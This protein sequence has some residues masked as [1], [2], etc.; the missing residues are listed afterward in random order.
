M[1]SRIIIDRSN[2]F[3]QLRR[4]AL[5]T[6]PSSPTAAFVPAQQQTLSWADEK[7]AIQRIMGEVEDKIEGL[8]TMQRRRVVDVFDSETQDDRL[9]QSFTK[10]IALML[11]SCQR[12]VSALPTETLGQSAHMSRNAQ[13]VLAL[14]LQALT[15]S[16]RRNH[17]AYTQRRSRN[18]AFATPSPAHPAWP[19]EDDDCEDFMQETQV[20]DELQRLLDDNRQRIHERGQMIDQ[21]VDNIAEL[22]VIFRDV[23]T[24]VVDQGTVLDRIE[25]NLVHAEASTGKAVEEVHDADKLHKKAGKKAMLLGLVVAAAACVVGG[26]VFL[27]T[28]KR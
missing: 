25:E 16:F 26:V 13:R 6:R 15:A 24:L 12:R 22:N 20:D 17:E 7:D 27:K 19:E 2:E 21:I 14:Q 3:R 8:R 11:A 4:K 28:R 1:T 5:A 23:A 18:E 9:I 10:E